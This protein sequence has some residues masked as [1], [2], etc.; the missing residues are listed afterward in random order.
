MKTTQTFGVR[1]IAIRKKS[2]AAEA[3]IVARITMSKKVMDISLKKTI[4]ISLW[5]SKRECILCR[6]TEAKQFNKYIDNTRYRLMECYQ[7]LLLEHKVITPHA[8][9]ELY[10][11]ETKVENT[12][13]GLIAYHN[14]HMKQVLTWGHIKKLFH[15]RK[16][17]TA[18]SKR[19]I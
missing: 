13:L 17:C 16:V 7:Q 4:S 15:Y 14:T 19:K 5:D 11:G 8:L 18:F 2:N 6:T 3:F 1:F 12:L 10:L 9:K